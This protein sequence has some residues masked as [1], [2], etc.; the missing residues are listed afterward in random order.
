MRESGAR[1]VVVVDGCPGAWWQFTCQQG[2]I[3]IWGVVN[4]TQIATTPT[5]GETVRAVERNRGSMDN[6]PVVF[7]CFL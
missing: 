3:S 1:R 7:A 2:G 6:E 5:A 4:L